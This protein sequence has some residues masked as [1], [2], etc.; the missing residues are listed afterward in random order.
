MVILVLLRL[1]W[2][3]CFER[4]SVVMMN[5]SV[6]PSPVREDDDD[7]ADDTPIVVMDGG[8]VACAQIS[9]G[10]YPSSPFRLLLLLLVVIVLLVVS[11]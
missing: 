8:C 10:M 7:D 4:C 3:S 1:T 9:F 2:L 5:S 6:S 11:E